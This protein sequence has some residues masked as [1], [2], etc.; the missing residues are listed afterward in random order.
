MSTPFTN[1]LRVAV[2]LGLLTFGPATV[3]TANAAPSAHEEV[4]T[5]RIERIDRD[6][7]RPLVTLRNDADEFTVRFPSQARVNALEVG[8]ILSV[9]VERHDDGVFDVERLELFVRVRSEVRLQRGSHGNQADRADKAVQRKLN[10]AEDKLDRLED[11]LDR[12]ED[13]F[14]NKLERL[15]DQLDRLERQLDELDE[16]PE[17]SHA[18]RGRR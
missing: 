4:V 17:N 8:D 13:Q 9:R 2:L 11:K 14:G 16:D 15:E 18:R 6:R 7:D 10:Q 3:A 12:L 1:A 5:G